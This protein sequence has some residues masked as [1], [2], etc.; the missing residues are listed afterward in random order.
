MG[1]FVIHASG[2]QGRPAL[3]LSA[4][5]L[6]PMKQGSLSMQLYVASFLRVASYSVL[7]RAR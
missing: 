3:L 1:S 4:H 6:R 5:R 2:L 7:I